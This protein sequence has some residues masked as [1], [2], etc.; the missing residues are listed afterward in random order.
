MLLQANLQQRI[1]ISAAPAAAHASHAAPAGYGAGGAGGAAGAE[2]AGEE[3]WVQCDRCEAWRLV[4]QPYFDW[5]GQQG[6]NFTWFC[7][8]RG[9]RCDDEE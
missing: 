2:D 7:E 1:G 9:F 5:L 4:D 6:D 3:P 8:M